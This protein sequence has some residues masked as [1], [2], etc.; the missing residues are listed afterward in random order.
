MSLTGKKILVTGGSG[1]VGRN[2]V[3]LMRGRGLKPITPTRKDY[4]LLEQA[5]VRRMFAELKPEVVFHLAGLI[6][7]IG[8]NRE[9]PAD[10]CYENL[11]MGTMVLH[12]SWRAGVEK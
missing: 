1:F 11:I 2:L 5:E 7:G 3:E 9:R 12:E 8:A 6:G 10:F 4:N